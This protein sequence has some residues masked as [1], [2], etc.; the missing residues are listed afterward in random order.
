MQQ[1]LDSCKQQLQ[2]LT[3]Y[4]EEICMLQ[5]EVTFIGRVTWGLNTNAVNTLTRHAQIIR[6]Y[7]YSIQLIN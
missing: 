4:A 6:Y 5:L 1:N 3:Q 2:L 7:Y